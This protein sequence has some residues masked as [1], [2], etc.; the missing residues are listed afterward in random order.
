MAAISDAWDYVIDEAAVAEAAPQ[1]AAAKPSIDVSVDG[2]L[3]GT[4]PARWPLG[5]RAPALVRYPGW[6]IAVVD[7]A[8]AWVHGMASARV[9]VCVAHFTISHLR[10]CMLVSAGAAGCLK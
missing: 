2:T 3:A 9:H 1:L 8:D 10:S 4:L 6:S 7:P 5:Q